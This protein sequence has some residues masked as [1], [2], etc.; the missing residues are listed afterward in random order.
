MKRSAELIAFCVFAA[1]HLSAADFASPG[2]AKAPE[3]A[4][5]SSNLRLWYC[6]PAQSWEEALPVGNGR[7]GAMVFGDPLREHLQ[8]NESTIYAGIPK[9]AALEPRRYELLARQAKLVLEGRYAE[10]EKLEL[11]DLPPSKEPQKK[12]AVR[13]PTAVLDNLFTNIP[14]AVPGKTRVAY[15]PLG[16]LYLHLSQ[17]TEVESDYR[18]ELDL[19]EAIARIQYR[20]GTVHFTREIFPSNPDQVLV[21]RLECDQPGQLT[22]DV[23]MNRRTDVRGDVD[24]YAVASEFNAIDNMKAPPATSFAGDGLGKAVFRG[25]TE[26]GGIGFE[27]HVQVINEGGELVATPNGIGVRKAQSATLLVSAASSF[28]GNDAA[29][30]CRAQLASAAKKTYLDLRTAHVADYQK[31]FSRVS[32]DLGTNAMLALPT[33][34]R[35]RAVQLDALR[36]WS[37]KS[38]KEK[39][40]D[41]QLFALYFQYGRYLMI[42]GSR[43]NSPLPMNLTGLWNDSLMPPWFG[44]FTTDI[45]QQM[46]YWPAGPC[47]LEECREPQLAMLE[48]L[49]PSAKHAAQ[50]S[51]RRRGLVM[52]GMTPF[53]LKSYTGRWID[54][55][56]WFAQDFWDHYQFT[57]DREFLVKRAYPFMKECALFYLDSFV[58]HPSKGW[59]VVAPAFSPENT[60]LDSTGT[61]CSLSASPTISL[62]IT[63]DLF[64]NC[65][66]ASKGLNIDAGFRQE[67][68]AKLA[69]LPPYQVS[70]DGHLQEWLEDFK[71]KSPGHRH[72]SHLFP[73]YPGHSIT[74]DGSPELCA[75]ARKAV[76]RRLDYGSGWTGWSRTWLLCCAARLQDGELAHQQLK[77]LLRKL[78]F[79]NLFD[80]HPRRDGDIAIFQID[81][82]FGGTAGIAEML[83]QSQ[84][85]EIHLLPALPSAW[86]DGQVKGLRARGGF[87][88]DLAWKK[89]KLTRAEI[90]SLAGQPGK[91]RYQKANV[92]LALPRGGTIVFDSN[93]KEL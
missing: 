54:E 84:N 64:A 25:Q 30:Q 16:D 86:P 23:T 7:L 35:L 69:Q 11:D 46:N 2:T 33:D 29:K 67:L 39:E 60:F 42:A 63:R 32:L 77:F 48:F 80:T 37:D 24:R 10:A 49:T 21:V 31:L 28:R 91:V 76:E 53:G 85:G 65:V 51:Y 13:P 72:Q 71:E 4:A 12:S 68:E 81:G 83:L 36:D 55:A 1:C 38:K 74:A 17:G 82:N 3:A 58:K 40:R 75:A 20:L 79:P 73:L 56:G 9:S 34:K 15:Q 87:E 41:P 59:L 19:N 26:P 8:L 14:P 27:A 70:K 47:N 90:R 93:L 57:G 5:A 22:F 62:G 88:V 61:A 52:N 92:A 66:A 6:Q 78:T 45:N 43:S 89:G 44:N 18:R 50:Q